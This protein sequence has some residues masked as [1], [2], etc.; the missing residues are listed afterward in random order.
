MNFTW[1]KN[2]DGTYNIKLKDYDVNLDFKIKEVI[3]EKIRIKENMTIC[4]KN[5]F[6][7]Y[8]DISKQKLY[9]GQ[10]IYII[11]IIGENTR[12]EL[13]FT[14]E[15]EARFIFSQYKFFSKEKK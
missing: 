8:E 15:S 2:D 14:D 11:K 3:Y 9:S 13:V 12:E 7:H 1:Y 5:L 4:E 10:T 6:R